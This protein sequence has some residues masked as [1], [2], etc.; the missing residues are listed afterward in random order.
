MNDKIYW[1]SFRDIQKNKN[2]GV[3]VVHAKSMTQAQQRA[4]VMGI[5]P[6]GE[7]FAT[8]VTRQEMDENNL[9]FNRLYTREEMKQ[10]GYE[11][12]LL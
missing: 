7:V 3:A 8:Q 9:E 12:G 5:N 10:R 2:L 1:L 6:G 11:A 4:I